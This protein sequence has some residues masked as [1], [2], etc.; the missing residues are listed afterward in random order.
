MHVL[1][2]RVLPV[3]LVNALGGIWSVIQLGS[4]TH[5]LGGG[6][7]LLHDQEERRSLPSEY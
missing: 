6:P 1:I 7:V 3:F 4:K 2:H 5:H